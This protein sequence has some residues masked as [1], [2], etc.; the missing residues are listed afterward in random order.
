MK[1]FNLKAGTTY[2]RLV[3]EE[4]AEFICS[5]RNDEKLNTYISKSTA[6]INTQK[7][8]IRN[9]K[10]KESNNTEYYFIICRVDNNLPIG[11]VRLYD[12]QENPK[13]FCWGSWILNENKTKYAA[14]ESALLVYEAGFAVLGF[15]QSHFEVMKGNDKVH[16]FHLKMG[17]QKISEDDKNVY[18]IF[19]KNRYEENKIQYA[20][21]LGN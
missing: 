21:F 19:P 7:E 8:W 11:T 15:E 18:Y 2:L 1:N 12:F 3:G 10:N 6:D 20:K 16:S 14:V 4:D 13:S 9:Y 5:L 17:A